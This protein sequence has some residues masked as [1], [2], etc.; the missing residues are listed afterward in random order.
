MATQTLPTRATA[1]KFTFCL[2]ALALFIMVEGALLGH[3]IHKDARPPSWDQSVHLEIAHDVR[4]NLSAG[5]LSEIW[6]A[7]PKSGMPPFPPIYQTLTSAAY[8][9]A[10][11][12]H[13]ALWVNII[14]FALLAVSLF[15]IAWYFLPD[16]RALACTLLF[17]AAPGI[18]ELLS[19]QLVDLAVCAWV[20]AAYWA[21]LASVEFTHWIGALAFGFAFG[22]GMLHK[23]SYF[24]YFFPAYLLALRGLGMPK[25][26]G[27]VL[28]AAGVAVI[29]AGPWYFSNLILLPSR[30][31]QASTDFAV[32]FWLPSAWTTYPLQALYALGPILFGLGLVGLLAPQ[33][34]RRPGHAWIVF[35]WLFFSYAFW[36]FV[37]N[38]QIRFLLPALAPL[39][40]ALV[41]TWQ[42]PIV[43][44]AVALQLIMAVNYF[45]GWIGPFRIPMPVAAV[46]F[47]SQRP[48]DPASWPLRDILTRIENERDT[49]REVTNVTLVANDVYFN[50]PS[51]HWLQEVLGV[52]HTRLRGV[53]A[54]LCELSEFVLLKDPHLGPA[55]VIGGLPE[56][57][58]QIKDPKGWFSACYEETGQWKLPDGDSALLFRQRRGRPAP[59]ARPRLEAKSWKIGQLQFTGLKIAFGTWDPR[60]SAYETA[61]ADA[62]TVEQRG[63]ILRGVSA[64]VEGFSYAPLDYDRAGGARFNDIRVLRLDRV[65]VQSLQIDAADLAHF[66]ALRVPGLEVENLTLDQTARVDGRFKGIAVSLEIAIDVDHVA[67]TLSARVVSAHAFG[68]PVPTMLF[69]PIKELQVSLAPNPETPFY[70]DLPSVTLKNGRLTV[71]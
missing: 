35:Y 36:T 9:S 6:F 49:T 38:R 19:T 41:A 1:A 62:A 33:Y 44:G 7:P 21:L 63:L 15:M 22:V 5:R 10:D 16:E 60:L 70:I 65:R 23:W 31:I 4:D 48:P 43:W 71:P 64:D 56:A 25:A 32:P 68:L 20:A 67:Q 8:F 12:A 50:A 66:L 53:N 42:K 46:E 2:S 45:F 26:R 54:R 17:C 40:L 61:R 3:F 69:K 13:A 18:Q 30:L 59:T 57:A 24:M 27:P 58:A 29:I 47:F 39:S 55:G 14:Y 11:P 51:F 52:K 34:P 28:A 37:P